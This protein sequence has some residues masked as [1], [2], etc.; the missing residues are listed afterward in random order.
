MI[1]TLSPIDVRGGGASVS[2]KSLNGEMC[3]DG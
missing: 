1:W 2:L 3:D